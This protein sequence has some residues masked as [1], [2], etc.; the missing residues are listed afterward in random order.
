MTLR[1]LFV[2]GVLSIGS[3]ACGSAPSVAPTSPQ[4]TP[5]IANASDIDAQIGRR[6][7]L[8]GEATNTDHGPSIVNAGL[9][10]YMEELRSWSG[11]VVGKRVEAVGVIGRDTSGFVRVVNGQPMV[12]LRDA[13]YLLVE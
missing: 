7:R 5:R 4:T 9:V 10:V 12:F 6:V 2:V 8:V 11:P 1:S 13:S 3:A